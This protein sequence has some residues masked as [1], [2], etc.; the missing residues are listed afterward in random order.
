MG[1][2]QPRAERPSA[3]VRLATAARLPAPDP[4]TDL[5]ADELA[6]RGIDVAVTQWD[7]PSVDWPATGL[8]VIRSTWD[9]HLRRDEFLA[10]ARATEAAT[11]LW[12][13]AE[14]VAW[15][16]HKGYLLDLERR[17]VP[18]VPTWLVRA[19]TATDLADG[20]R[21]RGWDT[22]V[23]KPAVSI[24]ALGTG[25]FAADD[26]AAGRHLDALLAAGDV[27]VQPLLAEIEEGERSLV[28]LGGE[29]SHAVDKRPAAGEYRI[30]EE[31]GGSVHAHEPTDAER[32]VA[33][34]CLAAVEH[35]LP[36]ARVDLVAS[37]DGP[38]VM[39]LELI[40]PSLFLP[41]APAGVERFAQVVADHLDGQGS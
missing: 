24:G 7:D 2:R 6:R 3:D 19:G 31:F 32:S 21:R 40:E 34:R 8:V 27:L 17:G 26:P 25:R 11:T 16:S 35:R 28:H 10:W 23:V 22:V 14:V 38:L 1:S 39:E 30:H 9:Y 20:C 12:N 37:D 41:Q 13:P 18:V 36:Y 4:D 15:N 33:R 5:V 29:L